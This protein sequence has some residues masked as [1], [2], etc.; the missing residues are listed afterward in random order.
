[1]V[2]N[3]RAGACRH[4]KVKNMSTFLGLMR[5]LTAVMAKPNRRNDPVRE[6]LIS[7]T[8]PLPAPNNRNVLNQNKLA[9]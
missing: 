1:M 8:A 2:T 5:N 6:H 7:V 9:K 4:A 3:G